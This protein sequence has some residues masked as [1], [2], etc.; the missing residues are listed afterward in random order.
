[1]NPIERLEKETRAW[2]VCEV[3]DFLGYSQN[4]I[5]EL[6]HAGKIE[7]WFMVSGTYRFCP[8]ELAKW[9]RKKMDQGS[10]KNGGGAKNE[11]A[12]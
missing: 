4:Y 7:G 2:S 5:Y 8:V 12:M 10:G 11:A 3:A 6:I 1:M 9:L